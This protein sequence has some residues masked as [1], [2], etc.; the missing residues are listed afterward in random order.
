MGNIV[1][2]WEMYYD[3]S[4]DVHS[5]SIS[6]NAMLSPDSS[7]DEYEPTTIETI[8]DMHSFLRT[9]LDELTFYDVL[10]VDSSPTFFLNHD[11]FD[12]WVHQMKTHVDSLFRYVLTSELDAERVEQMYSVIIRILG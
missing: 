2:E 7:E 4:L 5:V 8:T 12:L 9:R 10:M 11:E 3:H 1:L 6:S